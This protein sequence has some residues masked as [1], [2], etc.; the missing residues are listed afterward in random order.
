MIFEKNTS[1]LNFLSVIAIFSLKEESAINFTLSTNLWT[2]IINFEFFYFVAD[3]NSFVVHPKTHF[4][5]I[6]RIYFLSMKLILDN[7]ESVLFKMFHF[8]MKI[9][10]IWHHPDLFLMI[11]IWKIQY[12]TNKDWNILSFLLIFSFHFHL[13]AIITSNIS[14]LQNYF[15]FYKSFK[16][17]I[18]WISCIFSMGV[19]MN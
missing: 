12:F 18:N 1:N 3:S 7:L 17:K 2:A 4:P 14:P 8:V 13:I 16:V 10:F 19:S 11:L 6:C 9:L 5:I 15:H